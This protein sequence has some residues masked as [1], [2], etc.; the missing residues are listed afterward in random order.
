MLV[1][2]QSKKLS[3]ITKNSS[4]ELEAYGLKEVV[5]WLKGNL[6]QMLKRR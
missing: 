2:F 6:L 1:F 4:L 5:K 3:E